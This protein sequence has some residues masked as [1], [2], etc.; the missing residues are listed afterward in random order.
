[1]NGSMKHAFL[2]PNFAADAASA[3]EARQPRRRVLWAFVM[4][5]PALLLSPAALAWQPA[6]APL[7]TRWA[8]DVSP[9]NVLP[10]YPRPRL[11]R[12]RWLNLNGLWDHAI[13]PHR[14][15]PP[16]VYAGKILV[17]FPLESALSGV[18]RSLSERET[19]WYR[20]PFRV[21]ANWAGQRVR[22]HFGAVDWETRVFLNGQSVGLHRGGYDAFSFDLTPHLR[23]EA[24]QE[25]VVAVLDPTEGDLPRGKQSRRPEGIFYTP[26]SGIWQTVWLEPVP[27]VCV[28]GVEVTPDFDAGAARL[29]VMC[30]S[31]KATLRVEAVARAGSREAGR[32][33]GRAGE[34]IFLKL[35]SPRAWSPEDPF[36][37]D[38]EVTLW[39]GPVLLDRVGSYFGLRKVSL[40]KDADGV[41]RLA[42]NNRIQFQMGVLDQG[43][44]P[45]GLYT[46]PTDEALRADLEYVKSAG[47]NLIRKHVK[48]E[49]ERW[50]YWCDRLGLLVWQDMPSGN[51][52]TPA[53][54][55]QFEAEL[56]QLVAGRGHHPSIV[57][58][59]LFNEGWGQ[60]DTARLTAW[61]RTLDPSR[62]A[63]NASGWTDQRVGDVRDV[64][65]YPGPECPPTEPDRAAVLGE[66]GGLGL[67][68]E[69]HTWS[70]QF[71]G[72]Q[73]MEDQRTLA[74]R[75]AALLARVWALHDS[76][77]L[78][79]AV[80][81][82]LTDVETECNGLLTYDRAVAKL[83][84]DRLRRANLGGPETRRFRVLAANALHGR[85]M[86][87][88]TTNAPGEEWFA[89]GFDALD[90]R[91]G[92]AG[93]G[94]DGTPG[95]I[96]HTP[97]H[98]PE[99]WLR[100]EFTLPAD[101]DPSRVLLQVFHDEDAT[102]YLNGV[103]A[104]ELRGYVTDYFELPLRPSAV[105]TLRPGRNL[106]AVHCRQTVGGQYI[107]V[108]LVAPRSRPAGEVGP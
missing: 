79:A 76:F 78:S 8:R 94:A 11:V 52:A 75:F 29:R 95:A 73:A 96:I 24:E 15:T 49:P 71:W 33:E 89:P 70:P 57:M 20:R 41:P 103:L 4:L 14:D 7:V 40:L 67:G 86:W 105:A 107:D 81:T 44:W 53:G 17:P 9:T 42:L 6:S 36:L 83:D 19:L 30:A 5:L 62:L 50:Y 68:V 25:L 47:F 13:T 84:L 43:F 63:S 28:D 26:S 21:P 51:N 27:P 56:Y 66:F 108:G 32:S 48:V 37:Y 2:S 35:T 85:P 34:E 61:L 91:E 101:A 98:T 54:R 97:W 92:V 16:A 87:S 99:I 59:V 31:R 65:S 88:Y 10:E 45:D 69:G 64:H 23:P 102:I 39:D 90:W 72:Y 80:Y 60:Y 82:Q 77:G 12:E 104:A 106:L 100:R 1:M 74:D 38:L 3:K 93:F 55:A 22:L 18:G 58:W 46:A